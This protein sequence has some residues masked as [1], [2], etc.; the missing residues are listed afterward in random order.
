MANALPNSAAVLASAVE[1]IRPFVPRSQL[2]VMLLALGGEE[3]EFFREQICELATVITHMAVTGDTD[4]Q[5]DKAVVQLHYFI[6]GFDWHITEKDVDGGT[7]QAFGLADMGSPELG[8]IC[9]DELLTIKGM[10]L[11]L[12]WTPCTLEA[13]WAAKG[14]R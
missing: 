13:V 14:K 11:D 4:G 1:T 12:H 10:Q 5:G 7:R 8:Y 2:H 6:S 3:G 9:I